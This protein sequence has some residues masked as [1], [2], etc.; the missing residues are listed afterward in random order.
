MELTTL[1]YKNRAITG[2]GFTLKLRKL[3]LQDPK[4]CLISYLIL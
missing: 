3:K 4:K 2:G 1:G